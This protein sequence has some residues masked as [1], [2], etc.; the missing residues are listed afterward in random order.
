MPEGLGPQD[1]LRFWQESQR[2]FWTAA[3][4]EPAFEDASAFA[5]P[6]WQAFDALVGHLLAGLTPDGHDLDLAAIHAAQVCYRDVIAG[7]W[8]R[9]RSAFEAHRRAVWDP[10]QPVYWRVLRDRWFQIAE[11][12]FIQTLRSPAFIDAQRGV[13]RAAT[14]LWTAMPEEARAAVALQRRAGQTMQSMVGELGWDPVPIAGTPKQTIWQSG[15]T[16]LARYHPLDGRAPVLGPVLICHGLIGRQSM[17]DL[18]PERSMVRNLLAQ[19]VDVF[20][21]D[22]GNA[23]PEDA[24]QGLDHFVGDRIPALVAQTGGQTVVWAAVGERS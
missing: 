19:G 16:T 9:I 14:R 20:V 23:G 11:A 8:L 15:K 24:G 7:T 3:A 17:T 18:R 2:T 6:D 10:A 13:I 5:P 21:V 4:G 12:E 22:W 1:M